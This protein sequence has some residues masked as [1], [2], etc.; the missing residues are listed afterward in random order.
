MCS[1]AGLHPWCGNPGGSL[2]RTDAGCVAGPERVA[3]PRPRRA[4]LSEAAAAA[5]GCH[6]SWARHPVLRAAAHGGCWAA[7]TWGGRRRG[8]PFS[9]SLLGRTGIPLGITEDIPWQQQTVQLAPGD[10]VVLHSGG[11]TEAPNRDGMLFDMDRLLEVVRTNLHCSAGEL[12]AAILAA[13]HT[14]VGDAPQFDDITLL[15]VRQA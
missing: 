7:R 3:L 12:Q 5:A 10:V 14:F 2:T 6:R 13:V 1:T 15:I 8:S 4:K 11:V 9:R